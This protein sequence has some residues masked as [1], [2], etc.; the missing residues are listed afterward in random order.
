[1][2]RIEHV[3][4]QFGPQVVAL[5]DVSLQVAPGEIVA[6]VG[7]SGCGKSTLL[8]IAAGLETP[9]TGRVL[10]DGAPV[11]GPHP[12]VGFIFQEPRLLPWLT[13]C[14]NVEFGIAGLPA[15][16]RTERSAAALAR[17]GL[18]DFAGTWPRQLSGGMAQRAAIARALVARPGLLLLDEPF[19]ALD[20]FTKMDLQDHLLDIW[21]D[22]RPTLVLVTHDLEEALVLADR[23]VVLRSRPGRVHQTF[24][25][26]LPRPRR[27]TAPDFQAQKQLLLEALGVA[28]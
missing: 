28:A 24:A 7:A 15:A 1:M 20:P 11:A 19:S 8:R 13:V 14:Q 9:G 17:V 26:D 25:V 6:L 5:H 16:E 12:A 10:I 22:D 27:R 3:G 2:L 23:V 4:K 21:A 18:S